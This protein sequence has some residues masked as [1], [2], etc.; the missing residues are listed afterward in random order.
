MGASFLTEGLNQCDGL[1]STH[2]GGNGGGIA[3]RQLHSITKSLAYLV[4]QF[5]EGA[6][7][8]DLT[9]INHDRTIGQGLNLRENVCGQ[10]D[11]PVFCQALNKST[12][13][14]QLLW[15]ETA[16]GLIQ[17]QDLGIMEDGLSQPDSLPVA[18]GQGAQDAMLPALESEPLHRVANAVEPVIP[19]NLTDL[20]DEPQVLTHGQV[21]VQGR[22]L[23][24]VPN[25]P[26]YRHGI[27]EYIV[28]GNAGSPLR[29]WHKPS[30]Y[31]HGRGFSCAIRTNETN[32][33]TAAHTKIQ[34][35]HRGKRA[36]FFGEVVHFNHVDQSSMCKGVWSHR[37]NGLPNLG[38]E[39]LMPKVI[40]II[41]CFALCSAVN[42]APNKSDVVAD[43]AVAIVGSTVLTASDLRL[44]LALA[45]L[46]PSEV[47]V[48]KG[49]L[50]SEQ[51]NAIQATAIR[52]MAGKIPV[53]QPSPK[54]T[55][56]RL[57]RF[58]A[59]WETPE[60]YQEFLLTHGLTPERLTTVLRR[61]QIVERVTF[62]AL[63]VPAEKPKEWKER[64]EVWLQTETRSVMI[65]L[66]PKRAQPVNEP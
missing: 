27:F 57:D 53:Y 20:S 47:P 58:Q 43:R 46:D 30:Q 2:R 44:H 12:N 3:P 48:L 60:M 24:Q 13:P 39:A 15:V 10:N 29:C 40:S 33:L 38:K 1:E 32:D 8:D 31:A 22:R 9:A 34:S 45:T 19:W 7:C 61:R 66:I 35:T 36:K 11:R 62:R 37:C 25:G 18:L 56:A 54:Q 5:I 17:D 63:G 59:Q 42:A 55:Q 65:R 51:E 6:V 50:G 14:H 41:V 52:I 64:F 49:A 28:A 21:H 23:R 16:G 4:S 26:S